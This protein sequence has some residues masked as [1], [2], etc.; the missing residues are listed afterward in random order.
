M[1]GNR[2][3]LTAN[4]RPY[5]FQPVLDSWRTAR[6]FTDWSPTVFLEP[7]PVRESM[8]R[9]ATSAGIEVHLNTQCRGVLR[10]PWHALNTAFTD[11]ADFT[12]LAEDDVLVCDDILDMFTWAAARFADDH[13]LAVCA[14]SMQ[15][16]VDPADTNTVIRHRWFNPLVWGTWTDRWTQVLRDTWDHDYSSGTPHAPQSGWDWNINLRIMNDWS[17]A[18]P[19]ASRSTHIGEYGG[20]HM[21]PAQFAGSVAPTFRPRRSRAPFVL[22]TGIR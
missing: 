18:G 19:L 15:P 9:L 16:D 3:V 17:I 7:S 13:V 8:A 11:G 2:L 22:V 14:C 1:S 6:G 21:Q 10:N 20:T 12:V 5:Y 4:D